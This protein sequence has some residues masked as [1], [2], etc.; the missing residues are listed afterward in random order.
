MFHIQYCRMNLAACYAE[1]EVRNMLTK[2]LSGTTLAIFCMVP[3]ISGAVDIEDGLV[4]YLPL[5]EGKGSE[6]KDLGPFQFETEM[7]DKPPQWVKVDDNPPIGNALEFD[8]Q[9][10]FVKTDM[11]GQDLI[12]MWMRTKACQSVPGSKCW[13]W[14]LMRTIRPGSPL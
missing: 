11:A 14:P 7:S 13:K 8:G 10:N 12:R 3:L 1:S 9:E 2:L 4:L 6:V 5:N